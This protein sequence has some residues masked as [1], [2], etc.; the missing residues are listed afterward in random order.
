MKRVSGSRVITR[1]VICSSDWPAIGSP[2]V[3]QCGLP[4][5]DQSSLR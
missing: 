1:S 5:R 2:Q 3:G 4:I